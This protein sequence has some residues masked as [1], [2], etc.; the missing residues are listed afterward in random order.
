MT[1][2]I[3][4]TSSLALLTLAASCSLVIDGS[5]YGSD[6]SV[7][8]TG[9]T[10]TGASDTGGSDAS[11]A[12]TG[13]SDTGASD[14]ATG[15]DPASPMSC[16]GELVCAPSDDDGS[17][18]CILPGTCDC[19]PS[20]LCVAG[21]VCFPNNGSACS[22]P[23]VG[24][25]GMGGDVRAFRVLSLPGGA[26]PTDLHIIS[27]PGIAPPES[28]AFVWRDNNTS[29]VS[30]AYAS[31]PNSPPT[32]PCLS[33]RNLGP[34]QLSCDSPAGSV[35][36]A[37][38][39]ARTLYLGAPS[40]PETHMVVAF[41]SPGY[42]L[43]TLTPQTNSAG[44][45]SSLCQTNTVTRGTP[46]FLGV[47]LASTHAAVV[48]AMQSDQ[49]TGQRFDAMMNTVETNFGMSTGTMLSGPVAAGG[50]LAVYRVVGDNSVVVWDGSANLSST[51]SLT[52]IPLGGLTAD[53]VA[54]VDP[55]SEVPPNNIFVLPQGNRFEFSKCEG[56][57]PA[58]TTAPSC[59]TLSPLEG[60]YVSGAPIAAASRG[61][62]HWLYGVEG[63]PMRPTME[64]TRRESATGVM[65]LLNDGT[66]GSRITDLSAIDAEGL[67]FSGHTD[68]VWAAFVTVDR[69][70]V[71]S[72][73]LWVGADRICAL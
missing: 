68:Y 8:D 64:L 24:C 27:F 15:C 34:V 28:W 63:T 59:E 37:H 14:G 38:M 50:D 39:D 66:V 61:G 53:P 42:L 51:T 41:P 62:T 55:T 19:N 40:L 46:T 21:G 17:F 22:M 65:S 10:D 23:P 70:G 71:S 7:A 67:K 35:M 9:A 16:P 26:E 72:V 1:T 33:V 5:Q 32:G 57:P 13:T 43:S 47:S 58:S 44:A 12:D 69:S 2:W 54:S 3:R 31:A 56:F 73:E 60:P 49:R 6:G 36:A 25:P 20:E 30:A 48:F 45:F 29:I 18:A 4:I 52:T 11:V